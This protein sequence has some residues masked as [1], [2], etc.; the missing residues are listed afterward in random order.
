V[1]SNGDDGTMAQQKH[2]TSSAAAPVT[3]ALHRSRERLTSTVVSMPK[4]ANAPCPS[5]STRKAVPALSA[6]C[7]G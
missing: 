7:C 1:E 5:E 6:A 4:M 2:A 3:V